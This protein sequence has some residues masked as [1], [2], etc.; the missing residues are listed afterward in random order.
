[1][2]IKSCEKEYLHLY[3]LFLESVS[4]DWIN[5]FLLS[6]GSVNYTP[7]VLPIK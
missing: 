4:N 7:F 6:V 2:R 3:R 1:M 5:I